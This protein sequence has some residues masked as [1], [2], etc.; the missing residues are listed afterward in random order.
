MTTEI[1]RPGE[2]LE[3]R[4]AERTKALAAANEQLRA[5]IAER[6]RAED[7]LRTQKEILQKTFDHI[8]LMIR[9]VDEGGRITLAN[10]TWEHTLGWSLQEVQE[11]NVDIFA[12]LYPDPPYRQRVLD[13]IAEAKGQ[14]AD[15][16]TRTRDG[17]EIDTTWLVVHLSDGTR[18]GIGQD[19]TERKR[20]EEKLRQSERELAEA[21]H[22]AHIGSWNWDIQNNTLSWSDEIY[23]IYGVHPQEFDA[24]HEAFLNTIHP[25]DRDLISGMIESSLKS[26]EPFSYYYRTTRPDG[27]ERIIHSRGEV[28]GDEH[29]CAIR[30]FG[31]AQDVTELK[32]TEDDLR[33]QKEALRQSE[34]RYHLL[35]DENPEP[36]FVFDTETLALLEVNRAAIR[37]YGYSR[38][39][40]L[41][42][43]LKDIRPAEDTPLLL[44]SLSGK[45]PRHQAASIWRH[46]KK[47]GSIIFVEI[48]AH[49]L[50]FYGRPARIALAYDVTERRSLEAQLRQAQKMEAIGQL[51][52]GIAHDFNNLLTTIAGYS[53]FAIRQLLAQDPVRRDIEEIRKAGDHAASL[54]R[55]LLAF[56]RKQVLQP[57]V[58]D[59]NAV[60]S[61]LGK[62]LQRLIGEDVELQMVLAPNLGSTKADPGQIE[63]ILMNLVVNARDA[64][65]RGGTLSIATEN[66]TSMNG[67]LDN[68]STSTPGLT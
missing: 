27:Q 10:R 5:E 65:P 42:M 33:K 17:S 34:E 25:E 49:E 2:D 22:L 57:K 50:T 30:M 63:Q 26:L 41:G 44:E 52:G 59:L 67:S 64:M 15:F 43:T 32:Q 12:E 36:M 20:A 47:D 19:I 40:F 62:M 66:V 7:S 8:P 54:T 35:F 29:G 13:F 55:Q 24:T 56:S 21:Q 58:L 60:V 16:K 68:M 38:E 31:T 28:V 61:E 3:D 53:D 6:K 46:R 51:A 4:V 48:T 9:L 45:A 39:E 23:R 1:K 37:H 11:Q 18:I 14:W